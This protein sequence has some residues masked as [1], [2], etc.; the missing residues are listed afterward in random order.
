[1]TIQ[2]HPE[3]RASVCAATPRRGSL[4]LYKELV[5]VCAVLAAISL[6]AAISLDAV[7]HVYTDKETP[8]ARGGVPGGAWV[9]TDWRGRP[10][11]EPG[12]WRADGTAALPLL[13]TG[14]YHLTS[15]KED[16]TFAVVPV[17]EG[18]T[19]DHNSFY[20]IDS[21]QS[22]VSLKGSFLCPWNGGDTFRTVSDLLWRAGLPHVH[23]RLRWGEVNPCPGSF[24]YR[25]YMYNADLLRARGILVSGMFHDCPPWAGRLTKLPSNLNAVYTLCAHT[26][27]A[28]DNRM[29][30][31]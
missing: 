7:G 18:R 25:H 27:A 10:M 14:Y 17:P 4:L 26:A 13:P 1:M 11:G 31:L 24:D 23:D 28:F 2:R 22:W 30:D 5:A 16:A 15:G 8:T 12:M 20:G 19:F 21:A 3:G 9:L 6:P 29:G